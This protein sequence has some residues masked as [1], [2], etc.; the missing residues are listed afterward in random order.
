MPLRNFGFIT[1][2]H[3]TDEKFPESSHA[4]EREKTTAAPLTLRAPLVQL[5]GVGEKNHS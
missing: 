5:P 3:I 2:L 1:R 4:Q